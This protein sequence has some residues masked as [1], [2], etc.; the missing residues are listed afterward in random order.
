MLLNT[1]A[2]QRL[3]PDLG[4]TFR[5]LGNSACVPQHPQD[6]TSPSNCDIPFFQNPKMC[7]PNVRKLSGVL[8]LSDVHASD[9]VG[10]L[11]SPGAGFVASVSL[12][13]VLAGFIA[14]STWMVRATSRS[15][16]DRLFFPS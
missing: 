12:L 11:V 13:V 15:R 3:V 16:E 8:H 6:A 5:Q 2:A 1:T 10:G 7:T 9:P 14:L 4:G